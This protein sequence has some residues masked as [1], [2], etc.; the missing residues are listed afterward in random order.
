MINLCF[1]DFKRAFDQ[2]DINIKDK[3]R[4]VWFSSNWKDQGLL[5]SS[6]T[7]RGFMGYNNENCIDII[8]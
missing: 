8:Q 3:F 6:L 2:Q 7:N 1:F 4:F 5:I